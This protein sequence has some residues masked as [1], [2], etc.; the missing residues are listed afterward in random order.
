MKILLTTSFK[1]AAKRLHRN[2][3]FI[4]EKAI[5]EIQNNP[6]L[7]DLKVGDL[8]GIR[9]YKIHVLHQLILL[10]YTYNKQEDELTFLYFAPHENFY[11][12]LKK[13]VKC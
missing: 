3:V 8:A 1:R 10:A 6:M 7:G 5:Q 11:E 4:L 12:I 9:V 2:Q 13:Q